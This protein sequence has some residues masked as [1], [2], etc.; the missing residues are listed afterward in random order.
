MGCRE[1]RNPT[2]TNGTVR[3]KSLPSFEEDVNPLVRT[4]RSGK[5][6]I[7]ATL[8]DKRRPGDPVELEKRRPV[9]TVE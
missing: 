2:S 7:V 8:R 4:K 6:H 5:H 9:Q 1:C 3:S